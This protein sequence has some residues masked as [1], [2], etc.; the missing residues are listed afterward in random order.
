MVLEPRTETDA[1]AEVVDGGRG[2]LKSARPERRVV[3]QTTGGNAN[4]Y[5]IRER[6]LKRKPRDKP[7][8]LSDH[9]MTQN[10]LRAVPSW[11][12]TPREGGARRPLS[13]L[14]VF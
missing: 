3:I 5:M 12:T 1:P 10:A 2:G 14:C 4:G 6:E 7:G 11:L 8:R 9:F 13:W